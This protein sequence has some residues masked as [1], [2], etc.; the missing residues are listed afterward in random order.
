MC[1]AIRAIFDATQPQ[2]VTNVSA[3]GMLTVWRGLFGHADTRTRGD[4]QILAPHVE[5]INLYMWRYLMM[6]YLPPPF[7]RQLAPVQVTGVYVVPQWFALLQN[8]TTCR[9]YSRQEYNQQVFSSLNSASDDNV[10]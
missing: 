8:V 6:M 7:L 2:C 5:R 10:E 4:G 1:C 9:K 3:L